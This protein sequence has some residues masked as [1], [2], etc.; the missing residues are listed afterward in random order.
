MSNFGNTADD[1]DSGVAQPASRVLSRTRTTNRRRR[2]DDEPSE[3]ANVQQVRLTR[4]RVCT[5]IIMSQLS[6]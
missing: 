5:C 4:L 1:A 6:S 3:F 2:N